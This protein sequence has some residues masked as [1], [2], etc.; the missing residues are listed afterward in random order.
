MQVEH[1]TWKI[2]ENKFSLKEC[3]P[4]HFNPFFYLAGLKGYGNEVQVQKMIYTKAPPS[5]LTYL[6][7]SKFKTLL[8]RRQQ[9]TENQLS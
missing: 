4:I 6:Y 3:F 1:K 7:P 5:S 9:M 2:S 8:R